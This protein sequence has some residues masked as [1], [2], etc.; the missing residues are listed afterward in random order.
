LNEK[1]SR[2]LSRMLFN[3]DRLSRLIVDLLDLSRIEAGKVELRLQP[4]AVADLVNDIVE[5]LR[6]IAGE[7]P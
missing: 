6:A 7:N 5:G 3:I 1:Q 4:V 2:Y